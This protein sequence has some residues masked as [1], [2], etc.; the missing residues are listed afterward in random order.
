MKITNFEELKHAAANTGAARRRV[1]VVWGSDDVTRSAVAICLDAG[2]IDAVFVGCRAE[3]EGDPALRA[4]GA[5]VTVLDA[6]N[7]D[8]AAVKAVE[9]V[10]QGAADIVMKGHINTDN[11]L[12]AVLNKEYGIL[13]PGDVL[14]HVTVA[15]IPAYHKLLLLTDVA[16][17]PYPTKAQREA[18]VRYVLSVARSLGIDEPKLVLTHCSEKVDGRHFPFTLDYVDIKERANAGEF[19]PCI[20]DGPL[21]VKTA[22]CP[23][24]LAEK[25]IVS[26]VNGDAD[27]LIFPDIEAGNTFYKTVTLFA[28]ARIAGM[29]CG[30]MVPVVLPSRG[31]TPES[32][33][34]SVMLASLIG[35]R[36]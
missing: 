30:T 31:D 32:K 21:D 27:I 28:G 7:A 12:R 15:E 5:R 1:A 35:D 29:L 3:V 25:E 14:T 10:H 36:T 26:P 24:A 18:Q 19:G 6:D 4:H 34:L 8:D 13:S 23:E 20:A 16:V 17:I 9:L 2:C 11:L 22:M 33:A